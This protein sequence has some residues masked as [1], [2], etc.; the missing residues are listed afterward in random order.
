MFG[1]LL[2]ILILLH[3]YDEGAPVILLFW[4]IIAM[5]SAFIVL[6]LREWI[7]N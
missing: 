2:G 1:I 6:L 5:N 3:Y 7:Q 4:S